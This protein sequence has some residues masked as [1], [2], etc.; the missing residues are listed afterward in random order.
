MTDKLSFAN[1]ALLG[2]LMT[3]R[4]YVEKLGKPGS[5]QASHWNKINTG[6][7]TTF[8]RTL[9]AEPKLSCTPSL[10]LEVAFFYGPSV[11]LLLRMLGSWYRQSGAP[12]EPVADEVRNV[13]DMLRNL[14][15]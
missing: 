7:S 2:N 13:M 9:S 1:Q 10:L 14:T 4:C 6:A 5:R 15:M 8:G 12:L 3:M 11:R